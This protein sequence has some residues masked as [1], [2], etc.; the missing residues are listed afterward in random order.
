MALYFCEGNCIA[1]YEIALL[2]VKFFQIIRIS[3]LCLAVMLIDAVC[4]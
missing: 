1:S 4:V 3:L 2:V